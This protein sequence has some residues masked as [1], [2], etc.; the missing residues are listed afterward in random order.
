MIKVGQPVQY[1]DYPGSPPQAALVVGV[2]QSPAKGRANL[3]V[4][5]ANGTG[6]QKYRVPGGPWLGDGEYGEHWMP[7]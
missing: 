3:V 2:D 1:F 6:T 7:L 5:T 4:F